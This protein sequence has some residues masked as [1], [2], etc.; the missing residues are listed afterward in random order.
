MPNVVERAMNTLTGQ[1]D[2][3]VERA[4]ARKKSRSRYRYA[5]IIIGAALIVTVIVL[6]WYWIVFD[7]A[8]LDTAI[9]AGDYLFVF[10]YVLL[11]ITVTTIA[12]ILLHWGI[13]A[14]YPLETQ[15]AT[16]MKAG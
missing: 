7:H 10:W 5:G 15:V 3:N 6:S 13:H 1:T 11:G 16:E 9:A 14:D 4:A 12:G 2:K 8:Y